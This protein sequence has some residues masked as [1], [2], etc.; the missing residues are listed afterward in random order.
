M[1]QGRTRHPARFRNPRGVIGPGAQRQQGHATL[2]HAEDIDGEVKRL[3]VTV[4]QSQT[5]LVH[6]GCKPAATHA[7]CDFRSIPNAKGGPIHDNALERCEFRVR[8]LPELVEQIELVRRRQTFAPIL[9]DRLSPV[10]RRRQT[11]THRRP[12]NGGRSERRPGRQRQRVTDFGL[13]RRLLRASGRAEGA[14]ADTRG[15][16][17]NDRQCS[18]PPFAWLLLIALTIDR[19]RQRGAEPSWSTSA[20]GGDCF[21]GGKLTDRCVR[22]A[23]S[24][25]RCG[26]RLVQTLDLGLAARRQDRPTGNP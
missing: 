18:V 12:G 13:G 1:P 5:E 21:H 14:A 15:R 9:V 20:I 11:G 10:L 4:A 2:R 8:V 6:D 16:S 25:V 24:A 17:E 23:I 22:V 19:G 26:E 7:G 3:R